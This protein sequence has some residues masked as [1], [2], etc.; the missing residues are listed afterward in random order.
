MPSRARYRLTCL[1]IGMTLLLM[2]GACTPGDGGP[3][4][5]PAGTYPVESTF[6]EFYN[7]LG[8]A[9]TLGHAISPLIETDNVTMQYTEGALLR[10]DPLAPPS[11]KFSLAPLGEDLHLSDQPIVLPDQPGERIVDGYLIYDEFVATYDTLQ[12][13]RFV[14]K[15][16]TQ[17]HIDTKRGRIE[18]YF[19]NVGFYRLLSDPPRTVHLLAYGAWKCDAYCHFT[20]PDHAV[21]APQP[22]YPEPFIGSLSRLGLDFTGRPLSAPYLTADGMLEQIYQNFVV[23]AAPSS[24]RLVGLRPITDKVGYPPTALVPKS[25]DSR[26]VFYPTQEGLGHEVPKVFEDYITLHGGL[27]ISGMPTTELFPEGSAYRQCFANLCLDYDQSAAESLRIRPAALGELYLRAFPPPGSADST[28]PPPPAATGALAVTVWEA[29]TLATTDQ[30]Q[31]I[32]VR[33][34][35]ASGQTPAAGLTPTLTVFLPDGGQPVYPFP[36]TDAS[37][38]SSADVPAISAANGTI[39]PYQACL[40]PKDG[41]KQ[42]IKDSYVIWGNP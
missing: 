12:G 32:H 14:G 25:D 29:H 31:T 8:G 27:E 28:S 19:S 37:G 34:T 18:Q 36:A 30:T 17:V 24:I 20:V 4:V 11:D 23:F 5:A 9:K 15:P 10:Y 38:Q 7:L 16:L 2:A 26:L 6:R 40:E 42:C 35:D 21:V 39:I 22:V 13:D 1:L 33:S 41:P 3:T